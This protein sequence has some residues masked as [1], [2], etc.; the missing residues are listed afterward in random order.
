M[1]CTSTVLFHH[2]SPNRFRLNCIGSRLHPRSSRSALNNRSGSFLHNLLQT[3]EISKS[4]VYLFHPEPVFLHPFRNEAIMELDLRTVIPEI[5]FQRV[6]TATHMRYSLTTTL[7]DRSVMFLSNI[8]DITSPRICQ[9]YI[10]Q[11]FLSDVIINMYQGI[12]MCP[13]AHNNTLCG[14]TV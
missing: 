3:F 4:Y 12:K 13:H 10:L 5:T 11:L 8:Y 2:S 14:I 9:T 7:V 6:S 1:I